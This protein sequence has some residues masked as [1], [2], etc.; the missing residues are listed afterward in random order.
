MKFYYFLIFLLLMFF[1][2]EGFSCNKLSLQMKEIQICS[3]NLH[4]L[5]FFKLFNI[6]C[7]NMIKDIKL[8]KDVTACAAYGS[9]AGTVILI[10]HCLFTFTF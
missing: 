10:L 3:S 7:R 1:Y 8:S 9:T 6:A 5:N 2:L 4:Y